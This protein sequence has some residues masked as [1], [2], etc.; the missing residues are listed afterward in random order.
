MA[1]GD[2]TYFNQYWE[3]VGDKLHNNSGDVFKCG[4]VTNATVPATTTADPRWG[5]GGTT[6]FL[7]NEVTPGGNYSTGGPSLSA[8]ITDNWTRSV[9]T[10]KQDFDDVSILQNA[11]NPS[12]AYWGIIYNSTDAGKRAIGFIE[13]GGPI[14]LSAGDFTI[15]WDASGFGTLS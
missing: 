14:D 3:D 11:S 6:N 15:T 1:Q 9:G 8:V 10:N 7:T 2:V 13:L 4:I 12:G 5:A